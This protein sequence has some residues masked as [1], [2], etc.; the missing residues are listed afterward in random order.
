MIY[1]LLLACN[2]RMDDGG[3]TIKDIE[4]SGEPS[5]EP[6]GEPAGEPAG[7]PSQDPTTTDDDGDGYT[8][9][10]GDCNDSNPDLT[11]ADFDNDGHTSCNGDCD[12]T[13]PDAYPG[14]PE[15]DLYD[16]VDAD[17]DGESDFD[18][19]GDG[20]DYA[21][22][23]GTDCDDSDATR[24]DDCGM[25]VIEVVDTACLTCPGPNAIDVDSYGQPHIAYEDY[26][27]IWYRYRGTDG[28]WS[29][30]ES[31]TGLNNNAVLRADLGFDGKVDSG[32]NYQIGYVAEYSGGQGILFMYKDSDG[33]WSEEFEVD[34]PLYSSSYEVGEG[35]SMA[36]DSNRLPS[37]SY[38]NGDP[39]SI[40]V[41]GI[42]TG[43][44]EGIPYIYDLESN[45]LA[46]LLLNDFNGTK[47]FIDYPLVEIPF[48]G[49]S[50]GSSGTHSSIA[51]DGNNDNHVVFFNTSVLSTENQ[52][53][54][55]PDVDGLTSVGLDIASN[56]YSVITGGSGSLP[57]GVCVGESIASNGIYNSV[58]FRPDGQLCV[59]FY[60]QGGQS[61]KYGCKS[62]SSCSGWSIEDVDNSPNV[63]QYASLGFASDNTPYIAYH[64]ASNGALKIAYKQNNQWYTEF[65]DGEDGTNVGQYADL[66]VGNDNRVH[67]TYADTTNALI[68]YAVTY[69]P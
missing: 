35:L 16:G 51:I 37:F 55:V 3:P 8:E 68:K 57:S 48:V 69:T 53:T 1:L 10:Q 26:G 23:N 21:N 15:D 49:G 41:L 27:M 56:L 24:W 66:A 2:P 19:D 32:N 33:N 13:N 36:I 46:D 52:Y 11:P 34:G 65:V 62:A 22:Y 54:K 64:D 18:G 28:S 38:F 43:N 4:P 61:L 31:L 39:S 6:S 67:I 17:C 5:E 9:Q 59:A 40:S 20:Y 7:E 42:Y 14:N 25:F 63:G 44:Y 50:S 47:I 58:A 29:Q 30:Y 45:L 60:D 12:D